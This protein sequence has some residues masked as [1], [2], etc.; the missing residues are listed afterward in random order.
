MHGNYEIDENN[1]LYNRIETLFKLFIEKEKKKAEGIF[2]KTRY[3]FFP[4]FEFLLSGE[5]VGEHK[6]C[7]CQFEFE[8][9]K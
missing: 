2:L 8:E 9:P 4:V 1:K 7:I 6:C 5:N 3:S